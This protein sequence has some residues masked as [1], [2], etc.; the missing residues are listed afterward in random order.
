M[1]L[2][3]LENLSKISGGSPNEKQISNMKSVI[4]GLEVFGPE[5]GLDD[6]QCLA[7]YIAQLGHE[8]GRFIYDREA[9]GPTPAQKRYD[10]RPDLGNTPE[11]DGDGKKNAGRGPIQLTGGYNIRE[12]HKWCLGLFRDVPDFP[13][14]PNLINNDPWE[15]LSAIWYWHLGNP[16]GKSL[17][18][19]AKVNNIEMVTRRINGGTNGYEDRLEMY[20]RTAL[21]F[22]GYELKARCV[23]KFQADAGIEDDDIA[24]PETRTA[25]HNALG[26]LS[27]A[28]AE[29]QVAPAADIDHFLAQI[30][31]ALAGIRSLTA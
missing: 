29:A 11:R 5:S 2:L 4:L 18:A 23:A 22:L 26:K 25:L 14:N 10:I 6:P 8:S 27:S 12:F 13:A 24:G 7:H 19:Y 1:Q 9:W 28:P 16:T 15:G 17:N 30:D 3:T 20:V 21:V 31:N